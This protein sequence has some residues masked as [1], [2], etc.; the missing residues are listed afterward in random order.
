MTK[1]CLN[2]IVKNESPI[3]T[4]LFDT[5]LPIIDCWIIS[6]TGST[7]ETPQIIEDYFKEKCLPGKLYNHK[8]KNFGHNR[9]LSLKCAQNSE[10]D[11][12]YILL[13]DADMKLVIKPSF[14]KSNLICD[15]YAVK[16]GNHTLSYY[17]T[18]LLKKKLNVT[19]V[20]PTHEYY[21]IKGQYSQGAM[22]DLFIDDIGDGNCKSDKYERDI[23]LLKEGIEEEPNNPRYYFYLARSYECIRDNENAIKCYKQRIEK[24]AWSEEIWYSYYCIGN[25]Y[26]YHLNEPEKAIYNYLMAYNM[27]PLRIEN[28]YKMIELYRKESKHKLAQFFIEAAEKI[29]KSGKVVEKDILFMEPHIYKY[30]IDYEK[31]IIAYYV[32][33]K[34]NGLKI[35]NKLLLESKINKMDQD[36]YNLTMC[37]IKFYLKNWKEL[38]GTYIKKFDVKDVAGNTQ[39]NFDDFKSVF[40]PCITTIPGQG[41]YINLRCANYNMEIKDG[42][43]VYKVYKNGDLVSPNDENPVSTVNFLCSLDN[44]FKVT[45]N[46]LLEFGNDLLKHDFSVKGVEDIRIFGYKDDIYFVGN[47][48]EVTSDRSPKMLLGNTSDLK[49]TVVLTGYE[50]HKCQKNWAPFIHNKKLYLLYSYSPLV[51]LSP[52]VVTGECIVYKKEDQKYAYN[53]FRGGSPG[54]YVNGILY[55][56]I[57]EVVYEHGRI[58]YHRFVKMNNSLN[59]DQVSYPFYF[60]KLGIEYAVG[61]TFDE[62]KNRLLV[63]WGQNDKLAN[64]SSMPL[65]NFYALFA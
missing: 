38:G 55:F 59:I 53:N 5:I 62:K 30:M 17:N 19:C 31:S 34:E 23:R 57:H 11:F 48:R 15:V 64:L 25:I 43:L 45:N 37:N 58:Y 12:D 21:D 49:S 20:S 60:D 47:S 24:G 7:D 36:K 65:D 42:R 27:N 44:E 50:D 18:R 40:N 32:G 41:L 6:D 26:N 4:R 8:W 1:L 28:L 35:S 16:Q 2:M 51:I 33:E 54:F 13:L 3:I 29:L 14:K 63:S 39:V 22:D 10:L 46:K 9:D 52:D 56:L 61:A